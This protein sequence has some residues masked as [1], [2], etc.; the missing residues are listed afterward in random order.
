MFFKEAVD[1]LG[2]TP[3]EVSAALAEAAGQV[4]TEPALALPVVFLAGY[5]VTR[6]AA[7]GLSELRSALFARVTQ[8]AIREISKETF[9]HLHSLDL[10]FHL[11]RQTGSLARAIER[12]SRGINFLLSSIL[13]NIAPT[14]FEVS[15][16]AG[17]LWHSFGP[18]YAGVTVATTASYAA[19]TLAFT[20]WRNKFRKEMNAADSEAGQKVIESLLN[21]ETVKYFNNEA[22]EESRYDVALARYEQAALRT[23]ESLAFLNFGQ[24][25]ILS[26]GLAATLYMSAKGVVAGTMTVGDVV[27]INGLLLQ[28]S[29]PLNFLGMVYRETRQS[30]VDLQ[31]LFGLLDQ[32]SSVVDKPNAPALLVSKGAVRFEDVS[33]GYGPGPKALLLQ[34]I[35]FDVPAGQKLAIVGGSG[36][37]KST[38]LRLL[39]RFFDVSNGRITIDGQDIRDVSQA[40]LRAALGVIPQDVV[41]FNDTIRYNIR[42]G[43]ADASDAQVE[44]AAAQAQI[45]TAVTAMPHG[46]DTVVGER[47]LKLSGGEKQ[48]VA[49]ARTLLKNPRILLSDEATSA[50]DSKTEMEIARVQAAAGAGLT[51][52]V[53][54]HRLSTVVDAHR[55]VVLGHGRVVESGTHEELLRKRGEYFA[56]WARQQASSGAK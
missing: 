26:S 27:L 7:S 10:A 47:G 48:R 19:F 32:R 40:S 41:L 50:L 36:S 16:V 38:V 21:Y 42:Y 17:I 6:V 5:G 24:N 30:L 28:L 31:A 14:L 54:A 35:S 15:L 34:N 51:S 20:E 33:F 25:V 23:S 4:G 55:I 18:T 37:G 12:G 46:Y 1:R 45:H 9:R 44:Q 49:I 2:S 13:F 52:L 39:L 22:R 3:V 29:F 43:K 11:G 56:M 8:D 53:I